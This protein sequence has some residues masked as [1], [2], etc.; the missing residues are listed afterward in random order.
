MPASS[1]VILGNG[2]D[3]ALDFK[4]RYSDFYNNSEELRA[5]A[6]SGN[7]LC[8][9]ILDSIKGDLWSDLEMGLYQYSLSITKQHGEGNVDQAKQFQKEFNELRTAL[10]N[11]LNSETQKPK[12]AI[13]QHPVLGL[14]IEW[15][16]LEPEFL[17]FNYS[18]TT[19]DTVSM[20]TRT[21]LMPDDSVN[22]D[23]FIYQHGSIFDTSSGKN[24]DPRAIVVGIDED[25]QKVEALHSF[26]YKSHQNL[27]NLNDTIPRLKDKSLYI[28]YGCSLGK[29]DAGYF[30]HIF[31]PEQ[32]GKTFIIY[33]YG[34]DGLDTI[35]T[36]ISNYCSLFVFMSRNNV[37]FL[38]LQNPDETR[39]ETVRIIDSFL[40]NPGANDR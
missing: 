37:C 13:K 32:T 12:D 7:V 22:S 17:T 23:L 29:T 16:K 6:A 30:K 26:L 1:I 18:T 36:N 31:S 3:V 24:R 20:N 40:T 25:E 15:H 11:Y 19:L 33:Y 14:N 9:H 8:S 28:I 38:N 2:F 5:L 10:F 27:H 4:T 39:K 34:E 35:K 21:Y